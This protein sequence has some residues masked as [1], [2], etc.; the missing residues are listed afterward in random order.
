MPSGRRVRAGSWMVCRISG[1][2]RG[3]AARGWYW[4]PWMASL[5]R[6]KNEVG[7]PG[8]APGLHRLRVGCTV[9]Q[10]AEPVKRKSLRVVLPHRFLLMREASCCWT[11]ERCCARQLMKQE[12]YCRPQDSGV[13]DLHPPGRLHR[14]E[15]YWL[16]Y[17]LVLLKKSS[18]RIRADIGFFTREVHF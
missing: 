18:G 15:C 17:H 5:F 1:M 3:D 12:Y 7:S 10:Y 4:I 14:P 13:W 16:H 2:K 11:T 9:C 8:V 6:V